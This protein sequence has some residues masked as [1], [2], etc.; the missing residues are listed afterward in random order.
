MDNIDLKGSLTIVLLYMIEREIKLCAE[1]PQTLSLNFKYKGQYFTVKSPLQ[2]DVDTKDMV[3]S[4]NDDSDYSF[5]V[6]VFKFDAILFNE[7]LDLDIFD[8]H[9]IEKALPVV[10]VIF[11]VMKSC[12]ESIHPHI[13]EIMEAE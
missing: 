11:Y 10:E 2:K 12:I 13:N 1:I 5:E 7:Y 4:L 8:V 9:T 3:V 6:V